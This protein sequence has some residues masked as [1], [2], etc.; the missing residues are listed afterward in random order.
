MVNK[1]IRTVERFD[2]LPSGGCVIAAL[3]GGA[4]SVAMF[5]CLISIKE[6]YNLNLAAAHLNHQ[7]RGEE[8]DRDEGFCKILCKKYNIPFYVRHRD[9]ARL[10]RERKIS[11][12]LCGREERYSF[13]EELAQSLD[14]R[15]ATAHTASDNAETLIFNLTRGASLTGA[16]GIPAKRGRYIRPLISCTRNEIEA[17]CRENGLDYVTDSTNLSDDYTRNK[18]RHNVIPALRELNPRLEEALLRFCD[19]VNTAD[20]YIER[21]AFDLTRRARTE[22]GFSAKPLLEADPAVLNRFLALLCRSDADF[23]VEARHLELLRGILKNGGAVDLGRHIAVCKQGLLRISEKTPSQPLSEIPLYG[24]V[25]FE[26]GG[27]SITAEINN[28][29][30]EI[31][32]FVFRG[33]RGGDRF[34]FPARGVTKQLR[35]A[36][37]EKKIPAERR[38]TLVLL[39]S[40]S[41][42]LWCEGLGFSLQGE[43]LAQSSGLKINAEKNG[44]TLKR[45]VK[46][47]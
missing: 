47:A 19:S 40:G 29:D 4:D 30:T 1:V 17:Y 36:L 37:N 25:S 41:V 21:Q 6:K 42:V 7:L 32:D 10:A 13:F 43:E 27:L 38:D 11:E 23:Q 45:G 22:N 33:R 35:K 3:S 15:V 20:E 18:I 34:T 28:S 14:A 9:I 16:R 39:C 44:K 12:E 8:A 26:Y 46:D 2:M 24:S 31:N 5:H